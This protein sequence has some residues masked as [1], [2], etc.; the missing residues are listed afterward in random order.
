MC[1]E[2]GGRIIRPGNLRE[3]NLGPILPND[4]RRLECLVDGLPYR[5][6]TQVAVDCTLVSPFKRNGD[7]RPRAH[8]EAGAALVDSVR[9]KHA[10]YPEL[11]NNT[12]C[13]LVVAG[14]E[15]GGRWGQEAVDF[16]KAQ[17]ARPTKR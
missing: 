4:N 8:R 1:R 14:M 3:L 13:S 15:V 2:A 5:H 7:A 16:L 10:R 9:R 17:K 12:R 11:V 6:G